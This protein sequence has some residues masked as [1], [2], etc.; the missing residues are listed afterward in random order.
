M[1]IKEFEKITIEKKDGKKTV[2]IDGEEM[3]LSNITDI[4]ISLSTE[5]YIEIETVR[6]DLLRW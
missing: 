5:P 6:K 4:N 3:N 2:T 1:E